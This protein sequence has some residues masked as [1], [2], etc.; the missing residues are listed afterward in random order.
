[1]VIYG[2]IEKNVCFVIEGMFDILCKRSKLE[3]M[4]KFVFS[5]EKL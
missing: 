1:M 4:I 3:Y 5:N 2:G